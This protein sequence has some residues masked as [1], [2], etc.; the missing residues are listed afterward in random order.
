LNDGYTGSTAIKD[1]LTT[2]ESDINANMPSGGT[3]LCYATTDAYCVSASLHTGEVFCI[4][5]TGK[6]GKY[7]ANYCETTNYTCAND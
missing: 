6:A 1:E 3:L 7:A 5:G 2:I 4:D